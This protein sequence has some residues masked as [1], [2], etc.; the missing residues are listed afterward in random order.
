MTTFSKTSH[1]PIN[2]R[3]ESGSNFAV[4]DLVWLYVPS[5]R[6][7]KT[8]KF[9]C[10]W[11]GP[12]T[13]TDKTSA[14]NY[15]IHLLGSTKSLVV[16]RNRLKR[17]FGTPSWKSS[18][19]MCRGEQTLSPTDKSTAVKENDTAKRS[20]AEVAAARPSNTVSAGY[21]L[22]EDIGA[23]ARP[24]RTRRLPDRYQP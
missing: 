13:V 19:W 12:Y 16:H 23:S 24:Q 4:G 17:C 6:Q 11:R 8:R 3:K 22:T 15:K 7:G 9:S 14:V 18:T 1:K 10:L 2:D 5:I 20:Y 21:T